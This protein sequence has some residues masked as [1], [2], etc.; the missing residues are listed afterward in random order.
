MKGVSGGRVSVWTTMANINNYYEQS[1]VQRYTVGTV[2]CCNLFVSK[3]LHVHHHMYIRTF[4]ITSMCTYSRLRL[5][6][7]SAFI[8]QA[9]VTYCTSK[10]FRH[11]LYKSLSLRYDALGAVKIEDCSLNFAQTHLLLTLAFPETFHWNQI[12]VTQITKC[13][14]T[15]HP[16][17]GFNPNLYQHHSLSRS[18]PAM[19]IIIVPQSTR[20]STTSFTKPSVGYNNNNNNELL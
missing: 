12:Y 13:W 16:H 1:S 11:K 15:L 20:D 10:H 14:C 6:I 19:E 2:V 4:T 3:T 8:A 17:T 18:Y 7:F 9:S 5:S